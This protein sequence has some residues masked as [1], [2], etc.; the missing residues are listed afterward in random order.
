MSLNQ[1]IFC[2]WNWQI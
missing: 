1:Y 2:S